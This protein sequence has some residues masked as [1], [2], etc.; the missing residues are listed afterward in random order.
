LRYRFRLEN[1]S[2]NLTTLI[3]YLVMTF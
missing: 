3:I 2:K 1:N